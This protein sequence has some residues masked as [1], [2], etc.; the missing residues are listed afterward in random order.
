[1]TKQVVRYIIQDEPSNKDLFHGG[2]H[3]RT[4][5]SLSKAIVEFDEGDSAIGLDGSWGS[6]KSSVVEMA[7]RKL[8]EKNEN[9][10]KS[11]HFFTFDIWKSQGSG[12]RRSY[13]EHFITWAKQTFPN[14]SSELGKIENQIHG[15]T[16]EIQTNNQP[17][18]DWYGIV[19]LVF[20]PFLPIYYFWAKKVFD[21]VSEESGSSGDFLTSFPFVILI[22]F[23]LFTLILPCLKVKF[24]HRKKW[25]S[26][27]KVAI[28]R[29]L[30]ISSKQ[31]QDHKVVQKVREIDPND[32]EFHSTLREILGIVQSEKDRVV[33]VLDNIDRLPKKEIKEYWALVRSIFSRIHGE[34]HPGK[35]TDITAIVPYDRKLIEANVKEDEEEEKKGNLSS[36]ASRELF[37]KTFDEVLV[38]APPVLSNAREFFSDKLE[39]A[40]PDQVSSDDRFRAYRIFY[41]LLKDE[42]G[43]TTPRQIVSFVNDLSGLYEL[44]KG[45]FRLPTVAAYLA[46]QGALKEN[47]ECLND[48]D[49]LNKKIADL[50]ADEELVRNLAAMV[51]NVEENLAVQ[52]LLD[53]PI[54]KAIIAEE[55]DLL[56]ELSTAPGFDLRI[57]DVVQANVDEWRST[58][59]FGTAIG[60]ISALFRAYEGDAK[61]QVTDAMFVGF[62]SVDSISI[63]GDEYQRYLPVFVLM[64]EQNLPTTVAH[65]VGAV[66]EGIQ[67][68][69]SNSFQDGQNLAVFLE[70][71]SEELA[72]LDAEADLRMALR[73]Q[74]PPSSPEYMFGLSAGITRAGFDLGAFGST[75]L[76]IPKD[77]EY[78]EEQFVQ[79]PDLAIPALNQ[80]KACNL[81]SDDGWISIANACLS[82]LKEEGTNRDN[83]GNL[84][85]IVVIAWQEIEAQ[86]RSE[87]KL[88]EALTEGEFFRNVGDCETEPSIVARANLLFLAQ[89]KLG[90]SLSN[91]TKLE[92]NN[93][94]SSDIS[95][96]FENFKIIMEGNAGFEDS[97][98]KIVAQKAVEAQRASHWI[99]FGKGNP[100]H[101][102]VSQVV[103][104]MFSSETLPYITLKELL[105]HFAYLEDL[106]DDESLTDVLRKY[107][108]RIKDSEIEDLTIDELPTGFMH[109]TDAVGD[110]RWNALHGKVDQLLKS[111]EQDAWRE[112]MV[113]MDNTAATLIEKLESS[114]CE[115][116]GGRFRKPFIKVVLS[117]L[118]GQCVIEA[119]EGDFDTLLKAMDYSY[120]EDIWRTLR[121]EMSNV[122][123]DSLADGMRLFPELIANV[124]QR[125]DRIKRAE[126]DNVIRHLLIPALEG[127]NS[128]ALQVFIGVGYNKLKDFQN[129]AEPS[130]AKLLDGAW[131]SFKD[132]DTDKVLIRDVSEALYGKRKT[133]SIFD[134]TFWL[135]MPKL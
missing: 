71:A 14:K 110:S 65:F 124:A 106:F 82:A 107:A 115:L 133:K 44:H 61:T 75:K 112:H 117:V 134:P 129:A 17:I 123:V 8:T 111:V 132:S 10:K 121:E 108:G 120:H 28:S 66:F 84:L 39:E 119:V 62:K 22:I 85:E 33:V 34:S 40:L 118:S 90:E 51:F 93:T 70:A 99:K 131:K 103:F 80:F 81:L 88:D 95:D 47:P 3:E 27:Y 83:A 128:Q 68:E 19:V 96:A 64:I 13:L 48:G 30:L 58:G 21:E 104:E 101:K 16:R 35:N 23:V 60:N 77:S 5:H 127:I 102:V 37:S 109:A 87:I 6:G 78:F 15:K 86:R 41:E 74:T 56:I 11:Y 94:R 92:L 54:S 7:A 42:G 36:L 25:V 100:E 125:G 105:S 73:R 69:D 26:E 1:M 63:K 98:V 55:A 130:T 9:R 59:E 72:P 20:L 2:G 50:S 113:S 122:T 46:H 76:D 114:G 12:F 53:E 24:W 45:K 52:I 126:K 4:A 79:Y 91:P 49:G 43:I 67:R 18:L 97:Q 32:Y 29:L 31:H 57:E 116:D 89:E 38:V 135:P